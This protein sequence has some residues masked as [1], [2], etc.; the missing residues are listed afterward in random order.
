MLQGKS[1]LKFG[2]QECPMPLGFRNPHPGGMADNS[3]TF[4]R[5]DHD[6]GE[7]SPEGTAEIKSRSAVPSG[8]VLT[9]LKPNVETLG[10]DLLTPRLEFR[11]GWKMDGPIF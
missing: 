2:G 10:S 6:N 4:Q 9:N 11:R 8:L 5:W 7:P 3:P 1:H